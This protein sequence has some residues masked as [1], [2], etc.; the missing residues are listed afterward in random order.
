MMDGR[1]IFFPL[2]FNQTQ[3]KLDELLRAQEILR[4]SRISFLNAV[5]RESQWQQTLAH[6]R[7]KNMTKER[8]KVLKGSCEVEQTEDSLCRE[9]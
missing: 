6:A 8:L 7:L 5:N 9:D 2:K 1:V 3:E 4:Y